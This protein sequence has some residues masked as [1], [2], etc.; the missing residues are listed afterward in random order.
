MMRW[1]AEVAPECTE[2]TPGNATSNTH[3]LAV[4]TRLGYRPVG[5]GVAFQRT[6][7]AP[8]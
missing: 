2:L 5:R 4:Y 3:M 6:L 1:L 8:A 7:P